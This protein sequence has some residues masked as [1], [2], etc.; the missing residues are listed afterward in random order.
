MK[1]TN[2]GLWEFRSAEDVSRFWKKHRHVPGRADGREHHH[3]E[4]FCLGL[5]LFALARHGFLGYPFTV[6]QFRVQVSPD[7]MLR[8]PSGEST[9]LE[10]TRA[11]EESQQEAKTVAAKEYRRRETEAA[12]SGTLPHP[13]IIQGSRIAQEEFIASGGLSSAW[14]YTPGWA[15]GKYEAEWCSL[16]QKAIE[17]K[18]DKLPSF[19]LAAYHELIV[20][21]D[22]PFIG[23]DQ[24]TVITTMRQWVQNLPKDKPAFSK[25]S[26][27]KSLDVIYDLRGECRL[28][29]YV[30][31]SELK[32]DDRESLMALA[33]RVEEAGQVAVEKAI[34]EHAAMG[35]AVHFMDGRGRLIKQT[36]D[37]RRFQMRVLDDGEEVVVKEL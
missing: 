15:G 11:A 6:K 16:V 21:D 23:A 1:S 30:E 17:K 33:Q 13:V 37:G 27:I 8:W 14:R 32:R 12:A 34:S 28:F 9:G 3:E 26:I 24:G 20:Y 19:K 22:T 18:I 7:F 4:R 31:W 35:Q 36:P 29:P 10:V 2:Q 5:Y 25:I